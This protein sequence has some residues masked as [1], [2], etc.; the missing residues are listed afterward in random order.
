MY[1]KYCVHVDDESVSFILLR[2]G[3][4]YSKQEAQGAQ[5]YLSHLGPAI[6][7]RSLPSLIPRQ[8]FTPY[9]DLNLAP[10]GHDLTELESAQHGNA[11]ISI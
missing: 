4:L 3:C 7:K 6:L 10:W 5:C 11:S 8:F 1:Q 9:Y 2:T